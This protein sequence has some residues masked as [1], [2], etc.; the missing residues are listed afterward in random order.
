MVA[1]DEFKFRVPL[2][3]RWSEV[4]PQGHAFFANHLVYFDVGMV[5]YFRNLGFDQN[6]L[7]EVGFDVAVVKVTCDYASSAYLDEEI[8]VRVKV[9]DIGNARLAM[10]FE[11]RRRDVGELISQGQI[12][13]VGYDVDLR[14]SKPIPDVIREAI[15]EFEEGRGPGKGTEG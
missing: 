6:R 4:D 13:Y 15:K 7:K 8:E 2:R 11:L 10:R 12:V 5:E 1:E 3:V 9:S 14:R